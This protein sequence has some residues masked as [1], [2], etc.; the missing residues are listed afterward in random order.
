MTT[1]TVAVEHIRDNSAQVLR[2]LQVTNQSLT[3]DNAR[4]EMTATK[5]SVAASQVIQASMSGFGK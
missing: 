3:S 5:Q 1:L 4:V 2:G